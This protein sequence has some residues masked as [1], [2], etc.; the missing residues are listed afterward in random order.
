[1]ENNFSLIQNFSLEE[2][3]NKD[4][5]VKG[6]I[7]QKF[8]LKTN[9]DGS[10]SLEGFAIHG[11]DDFI[12]K[13]IFEI[14]ES[15]INNCV[16]SLKGAKLFKD[17]DTE[18]VDSIIGR[19]NNSK[20]TFDDNADMMGAFYNASLVVDD[21]R[22]SEKI[23]KGL[24]D[25]TSI[26]FTS[27]VECSIC[28]KPYLSDECP[29]LLL[30]DDMHLVC[31]NMHI[32]ELSVVPFGADP[33]ATVSGSSFSNEEVN[34]LKEKFTKQKES[35]IMSKEDT[36]VETL[37]SEN[38]TLSQEVSDLKAQLE[39][40]KTNF[41]KEKDALETAHE[42]EVL[43]LQQ[44]KNA[45]DKQIEEMQQELS[46]FRAE[47]EAREAEK[48]QSKRDEMLALAKELNF[49]DKIKEERLN[50]EEYIDDKLDMLTEVKSRLTK[51]TV[52]K[53]INQNK[54]H[55]QNNDDDKK[56]EAFS[57]LINGFHISAQKNR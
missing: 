23:D 9:D 19:V 45:V 30:F 52:P 48:L 26:G 11:G 10:K 50:D 42:A 40:Q 31:R 21:S 27:D 41:N 13:G 39:Q 33:F 51:D 14:P 3:D 5:L 34:E 16:K 56:Y 43:T 17:H 22:L 47:A 37:K 12:V 57:G 55:S 7:H 24:V 8:A 46:T 1:M 4:T 15:E 18:H 38:L 2:T 53:P 28:G 36:I 35:F 49:E 20:K 54:Y 25:A 44:E 6:K 29:H 32:H